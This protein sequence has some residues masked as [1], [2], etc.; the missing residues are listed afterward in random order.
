[1]KLKVVSRILITLSIISFGSKVFAQTGFTPQ[2]LSGE[3]NT[4]YAEINPILSPDGKTLYFTRV[5]HPENRFGEVDSQDIWCTTLNPDGTWSEAK[6]L[7]NT[8]NLGRYNAIFGILDD[9]KTFVI[10]G[11]YTESG[12][13]WT[14]RGLSVIERIDENTWGTPRPLNVKG[15]T[16]MNKGLTTTAYLTPDGKYLLT[17]FSKR[18]GGKNHSIYLSVKEGDGYS[19]PQKVKIG[20]GNLGESYEAPF[21]SKDGNALFFSCKVDGNNNIYMANR[22]DDTYLNWS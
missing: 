13:Y 2:K 8:I 17:S 22:T 10:N 15:F 5:N 19:K 16:R 1:M 3:I 9:G 14:E 6:R 4:G 18:A 11:H 21:L 20:D 12:K 7:P